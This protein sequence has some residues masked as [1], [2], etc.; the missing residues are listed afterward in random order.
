MYGRKWPTLSDMSVSTNRPADT[1][2]SGPGEID[3]RLERARILNEYR[4]GDLDRNQVC[5]AQPELHR[6]A[7]FCG[8]PTGDMC[9]VCEEYEL[10]HV[11]YVFGPRLPSS[12]RCV[13]TK[14]EM[15]RLREKAGNYTGYVVEVCK[16]CGW[17]HLAKTYL[18]RPVQA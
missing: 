7:E 13:T 18:L 6:N 1:A 16:G 10:V 4:S 14:A 9:P 8:T 12:G 2:D 3:Y 17:N 11:T 5:D 15:K